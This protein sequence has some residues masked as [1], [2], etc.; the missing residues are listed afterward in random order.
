MP[1]TATT[2][3]I[4]PMVMKYVM[5][6]SMSKV[7][8][9]VLK[10][11]ARSR[12]RSGEATPATLCP[13]YATSPAP[14]LKPSPEGRRNKRVAEAL[15]LQHGQRFSS[16]R[17]WHGIVPVLHYNFLAL[18]RVDE[19]EEFLHQLIHG[20]CGL[21]VDVDVQEARERIRTAQGV[22]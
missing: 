18:F 16:N 22:L 7:D 1:S 20:F 9:A 21:L 5:Q 2:T 8:L 3:A 14:P 6:R 11:C 19:L 13:F 17:C 10:R 12:E 4:P 15:L